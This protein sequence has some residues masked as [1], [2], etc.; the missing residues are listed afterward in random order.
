MKK[1]L[2][3]LCTIGL[4]LISTTTYAQKLTFSYD[5]AGNQ[6]AR[7][8]VCVN[9]TGTG[10]TASAP[11]S[12]PL[13]LDVKVLDTAKRITVKRTITASPNPFLENLNVNWEVEKDITVK[14][15][16]VFTVNGIKTHEVNPG[17]NLKSVNIPFQNL[18]IGMYVLYI[19]FS[20][21]RKES[22]KVIKK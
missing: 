8:W 17:P 5:A 21:N 9:C 7:T 3:R 13:K 4:L 16:A 20:D 18:A 14:S 15:I 22:I 11:E 19:T 12:A 2:F 10:G 1:T 6:T